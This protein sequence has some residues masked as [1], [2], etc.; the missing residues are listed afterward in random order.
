MK[1]VFD[2]TVGICESADSPSGW[3]RPECGWNLRGAISDTLK[4]SE[5]TVYDDR[6]FWFLLA[7]VIPGEKPLPDWFQGKVAAINA[8]LFIHDY[9][10][11]YLDPVFLSRE[12]CHTAVEFYFENS[13]KPV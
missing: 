6:T 1:S 5:R 2:A 8:F 9:D 11:G 10:R 13:N 12:G 7:H 3:C 4:L